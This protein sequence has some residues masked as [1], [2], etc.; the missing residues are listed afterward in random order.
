VVCGCMPRV[1]PTTRS[2]RRVGSRATRDGGSARTGQRGIRATVRRSPPRTAIPPPVPAR[3]RRPTRRS[4]RRAGREGLRTRRGS[5]G[6]RARLREAPIEAARRPARRRGRAAGPGGRGGCRGSGRGSPGRGGWEKGRRSHRD[7]HRC[8]CPSRI[9]PRKGE[10]GEAEHRE[11][12]RRHD[13]GGG[14]Q[15]DDQKGS[16]GGRE[17]RRSEEQSDLERRP[18]ARGAGRG[19]VLPMEERS[20]RSASVVRRIGG[21]N[22]SPERKGSP[23]RGPMRAPVGGRRDGGKVR[24]RPGFADEAR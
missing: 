24:N 15:P 16:V 22:V 11:R 10:Q 1:R 2:L 21:M 12:A 17:A 3:E 9:A 8:R 7:G 14:Y 18:G 19:S 13:R 23:P 4:A 5:A 20:H 6:P